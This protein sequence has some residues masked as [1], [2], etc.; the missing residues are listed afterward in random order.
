MGLVSRVLH[1][2]SQRFYYAAAQIDR[3]SGGPPSANYR[4]ESPNRPVLSDWRTIVARIRQLKRDNPIIR[5]SLRNLRNAVLENGIKIEP[6]VVY[7]RSQ[8]LAPAHT[9]EMERLWSQW[10][11]GDCDFA[12]W[13]SHRKT[14]VMI[15][16]QVFDSLICDGEVFVI[17]RN[18]RARSGA[19]QLQLEVR[20]R[21]LLGDFGF[22]TA[23]DRQEGVVY[24]AQ[25][26]IIA[27]R[28][29]RSLNLAS[30]EVEEVPARDVLH[31]MMP[32]R[33]GMDTGDLALACIV[34]QTQDLGE[35]LD[36]ELDIKALLSRVAGFVTKPSGGMFGEQT[37][38]QNGQR[39]SL[40]DVDRATIW[41]I[42]DGDFKEVGINR[43]GAQ[44]EQFVKAAQRFIAV[45]MG[46]PYSMISADFSSS[47]FMNSRIEMRQCQPY[48]Q[49]LRHL[50][51]SQLTEG[52][53]R[54]FAEAAV[55][56]PEWRLPMAGIED[57]AGHKTRVPGYRYI[58]VLKEIQADVLSI[59]N[60]LQSPQQVAGEHGYDYF[61]MIDQIAEAKQYADAAGVSLDCFVEPEAPEID[62]EPDE[63]EVPANVG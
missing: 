46:L 58:D 13:E 24:D 19:V 61:E 22:A 36:N 34:N 54:W 2:I 1:S 30:Y 25:N 62:A 6:H 16:Q 15:Q 5:G 8:K 26:R 31:I 12:G 17:R 48:L 49:S 20:E 60:G 50:V 21:D 35:Y 47:T 10:I 7:T 38:E 29:R 23:T 59:R 42:P 55:M 57:I 27:Y 3:L 18:R 51:V 9:R 4:R 33:P 56:A 41:E 11:L 28:F 43:P 40:A 52:V 14:F 45:G 39:I 37:V 63:E 32:D 53:Y 44:F